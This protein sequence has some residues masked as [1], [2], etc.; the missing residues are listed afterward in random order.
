LEGEAESLLEG[1]SRRQAEY[2]YAEWR[3]K[4]YDAAC[5]A[6]TPI[7]A[8]FKR[9]L[10]KTPS[11]IRRKRFSELYESLLSR[12]I[13][14]GAIDPGTMVRDGII[15]RSIGSGG[16]GTVWKIR[17]NDNSPDKA[18]KVYHPHDIRDLEKTSRFRNGFEAMDRLHHN[19]IVKVHRFTDCPLGFVMDYIPGENLREIDPVNTIRDTE[20]QLS[21]LIEIADTVRHAHDN[22]VIHRDVK[23]ENIIC[24]QDEQAGW[25]PFLTDFDLAWFTTQTRRA[26]K[27]ALGVVY[28]A[29]P[30]QHVAFDPKKA[31]GKRPTLDVF[32]FGQLCHF[33][34][35]GIDPDPVRLDVNAE[36]IS[37]KLSGWSTS[38]AVAQFRELYEGCTRWE[39]EERIGDF[40]T[41]LATLRD[42][43]DEITYTSL[44]R[45]VDVSDFVAELFFQLSGQPLDPSQQHDVAF[46]SSSGNWNIQLN[47][48]ERPISRKAK[49]GAIIEAHFTPNMLIG[50][51]RIK[52]ERMRTVRNSRVDS[53]L[54]SDGS[55]RRRSGRQGSYEV[56]VDFTVVSLNIRS[57]RTIRDKIS[58]VIG[59]LE[60]S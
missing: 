3:T 25:T 55:A 47:H 15:E 58:R 41:I 29:A 27:S 5:R 40:D 30:E 12:K 6:L 17:T 34:L 9:Q 36:R 18:Y 28:Y 50:L 32:S 1:Y 54:G 23:P 57:V 22:D 21:L 4:G 59:A 51:E 20:S 45:K 19:H 44:D 10:A 53:V 31:V 49:T 39:P 60:R 2:P 11:L 48:R 14:L 24:I 8:W 56:Y 43:R 35:T 7:D 42:I 46:T 16:F 33:I 38:A 13:Q 37:A 26:T 52:N